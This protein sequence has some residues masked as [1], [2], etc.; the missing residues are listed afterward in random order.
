[1][2]LNGTLRYRTKEHRYTD[3]NHVW[4][5]GSKPRMLTKTIKILQQHLD[6]RWV[7]VPTIDP[8]EHP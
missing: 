5:A 1:M 2:S 3:P 8:E 4:R 7:D 6:G